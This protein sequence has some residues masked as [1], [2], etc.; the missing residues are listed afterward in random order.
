MPLLRFASFLTFVFTEI[1]HV[2]SGNFV[3][4]VCRRLFF[5]VFVLN[6]N[7]RSL[8]RE[9]PLVEHVVG[10]RGKFALSVA[11]EWLFPIKK[12]VVAYL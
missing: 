5:I 10:I 4:F 12:F 11:I 6:H 1:F 7:L 9:I 2:L 3:C 8:Q